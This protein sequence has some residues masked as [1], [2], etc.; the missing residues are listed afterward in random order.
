LSSI[1]EKNYGKVAV[2]LHRRRDGK[3]FLID[4]II[5]WLKKLLAAS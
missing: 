1:E 4:A 2:F 3:P 5:A